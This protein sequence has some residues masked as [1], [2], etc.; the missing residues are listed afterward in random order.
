MSTLDEALAKIARPRNRRIYRRTSLFRKLDE[1]AIMPGIWICGPPGSG[2]TTLISSYLQEKKRTGLW[3]QIDHGDSDVATFFW[4]MRLAAKKVSAR[5]YSQLQPYSSAYQGS[6]KAFAARFFEKLYASLPPNFLIVLDD[7]HL[8]K[9]GAD[10]D[11]VVV[12]AISTLPQHGNIAVVSREQPPPM[13]CRLLGNEM[14]GQIGWDDLRLRHEEVLG[15]SE[16]RQPGHSA[17]CFDNIESRVDGWAA[18]LI[19]QLQDSQMHRCESLPANTNGHEALFG[20]FANEVLE[21]QKPESRK[22]VMQLALLPVMTLEMSRR[23][24]ETEQAVRLLKWLHRNNNFVELQALKVPIYRFHPLFREFLLDQLKLSS[25]EAELSKLQR[26]A[27]EILEG[28]GFLSAARELYGSSGEWDKVV[29]LISVEAPAKFRQGRIR[30][31]EKSIGELP[32]AVFAVYPWLSYWLGAAR[33]FSDPQDAHRLFAAAFELFQ[34]ADDV[35]GSRASWS[36]AVNSLL[37]EWGDMK[38]LDKWIGR[39]EKL[40]PE[41][42]PL[43]TD[44]MS[45]H[46]VTAMCSALSICRPHSSNLDKFVRKT[47]ELITT[48]SDRTFSLMGCNLLLIFYGWLGE[49]PKMCMLVESLRPDMESENVSDAHRV[50]WAAAE[51]WLDLVSGAP[52]KS[53]E[54]S[55]SALGLAEKCGVH[56]F[57]YKFHGMVTQANLILGNTE[58]ARSHIQQY[59]QVIPGH[60][61]LLQFHVHFLSAWQAWQAGSNSGAREQLAIAS[62]FLTLAGSAPIISTK[63]D[64]AAAILHLESGEI[65][66]GKARLA[67]VERAANATGS[68]WLQYHCSL[69]TANFELQLGNRKKCLLHLSNALEIGRTRGL[70][71][72]DWWDARSMSRLCEIALANNIEPQ[73]VRRIIDEAGLRPD[74]II[75]APEAWPW[76]VKVKVLGQFRLTINGE[77]V[78][79]R[80]TGHRKI[81]ELVKALI[82]HG[83]DR[84]AAA[85]LAD[86]VWPD[87]EGDNARNALKTT[88]HRL[89]KLLGM[90]EA[91]TLKDGFL[92]LNKEYCW[93]DAFVF[94]ALART[95]RSSVDR[96]ANLKKALALYKGPLLDN[97]DVVPWMITPREKLQKTAHQIIMEIGE[98]H[99]R[100]RKWGKAIQLYRNGLAL[101][102]LDEQVWR[103]LMQCY[104]QSG[105]KEDA[106]ASYEQ[107]CSELKVQLARNPSAKTKMLAE[108]ISQSL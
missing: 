98:R 81:L 30:S 5:S 40:F 46:A 54:S 56:M 21:K 52:E 48:T 79:Q 89:R 66:E 26:K 62:S 33:M 61:S 6:L 58:E 51:G 73:H 16:L 68:A 9:D 7:Y 65:S 15:I 20:Y 41:D 82:A 10:L 107:C 103:H 13:F 44:A 71:I 3:Y 99:E 36:G 67:N 31:L 4:Y 74:S 49:L 43:P 63:T 37:A 105:R 60:A 75:T 45:A 42:A 57:D 19:F 80:I 95:P 12:Q 35:A 29:E 25:S 77:V 22:T 14:L 11:A 76:P 106:L 69:L 70:V 17:R 102:N 59:L 55:I 94:S 47:H 100:R 34:Q 84:V 64:I 72:T 104:R 78:S 32:E 28:A 8:N 39:G 108:S 96:V 87:A 24:T 90:P 23:L 101:D 85:R 97:E 1:A 92:S 83:G 86:A 93:V 50:M 27:A 91:I 88:V 53:I 2:K 18:G 38:S